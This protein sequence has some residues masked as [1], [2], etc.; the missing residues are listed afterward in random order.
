MTRRITL[1]AA[2]FALAAVFIGPA[3]AK[4]GP[5][6][7]SPDQAQALMNGGFRQDVGPVRRVS[8]KEALQAGAVEGA[9]VEA[10]SALGN[11]YARTITGTWGTWPYQQSVH[12]YT[13]WCAT[14]VITYRTTHV[15]LETTLCS[16]S[17][18]YAFRYAGGLG[19]PD[20]IVQAGGDFSCPTAIPWITLHTARWQRDQYHWD[21]QSWMNSWS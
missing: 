11:C 3:A 20:V 9:Q 13:Y 18:A 21:G 1:A 6:P 14:A 16:G 15:Q 8:Q 2:L 12:D 19:Y 7:A 17:G 10:A 4:K 5:Q